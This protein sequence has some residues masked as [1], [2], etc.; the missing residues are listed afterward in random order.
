[1][2]TEAGASG[3]HGFL[4]LAEQDKAP[5]HSASSVAAAVNTVPTP[6]RLSDHVIQ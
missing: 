4:P 1:M 6:Q 5:R 3:F 2:T